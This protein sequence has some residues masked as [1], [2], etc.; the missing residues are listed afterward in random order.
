MDVQEMVLVSPMIVTEDMVLLVTA[1]DG[2]LLMLFGQEVLQLVEK[3]GFDGAWLNKFVPMLCLH[4]FLITSAYSTAIIDVF[5]SVPSSRTGI[6]PYN[7]FRT[8]L[9]CWFAITIQ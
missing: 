7:S 4:F 5:L 1:G 2:V 6:A 9:A 3:V 8:T